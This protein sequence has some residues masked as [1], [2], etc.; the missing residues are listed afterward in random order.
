MNTPAGWA[1]AQIKEGV[2]AN[3]NARC[4]TPT[5]D[6]NQPDERRWDDQ[7]RALPPRF[8][9]DVLSKSPWRERVGALGVRIEGARITGD[10]DLENAKLDRAVFIAGSR[11]DGNV[12]LRHARTDSELEF[13]GSRVAG[14]FWADGLR[15]EQTLGL[16]HGSRFLGNVWLIAA[17]IDG[18]LS[19]AGATFD[20][21][22]NAE[23][24]QVGGNLE[25]FPWQGKP[26]NLRWVSL[27]AARISGSVLMQSATFLGEL[28]AQGIQVGDSFFMKAVHCSVPIDM[29]VAHV[30][31]YLDLSGATLSGLDLSGAW[32]GGAFELADKKMPPIVWEPFNG[33]PAA[34]RLRNTRVGSLVDA[35]DAWPGA[36][37]LYLDGFSF[38]DLGGF[39][40]ETAQ[41]ARNRGMEWWDQ[42]VRRD[43]AYSPTPYAQLAAALIAIGDRDAANDIRFLGRARERET[44]CAER[45]WASCLT[46]FPLEYVAGFGIGTYTFRVLD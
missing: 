46:L 10:I 36:G 34:L 2:T 35:P 44:R 7:C 43:L 8:L 32:I 31:R 18:N 9:I 4:N 45:A 1:W 6:P 11:V 20:G 28:N 15:A 30:G 16:R 25:L 21:F 39:A 14:A 24:L 17:K 40:G 19:L 13:N 27:E 29:A 5:L 12:N 22:L 37:S 41:Q 26:T 38:A 23:Y 42:W 33:K 3:F